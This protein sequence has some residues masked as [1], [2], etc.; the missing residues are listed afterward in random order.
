MNDLQ[1][2]PASP[3]LRDVIKNFNDWR[4][5]RGKMGKTPHILMEQ[6]F[7]LVGHYKTSDICKSLHLCH[8]DFKRKLTKKAVEHKHKSKTT[9]FIELDAAE[10]T[11]PIHQVNVVLSRTDGTTMQINQC[12]STTLDKLISRFLL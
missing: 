1:K 4:E 2:L 7:S 3:S 8:S 6:A 11:Q 9:T 5:T 12:N 10:F